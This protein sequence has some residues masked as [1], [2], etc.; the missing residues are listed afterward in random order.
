M[1][2]LVGKELIFKAL[3]KTDQRI[4]EAEAWR[5]VDLMEKNAAGLGRSSPFDTTE[6]KLEHARVLGHELA[7]DTSLLTS[8]R[9][10]DRRGTRIPLANR[11]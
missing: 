3:S 7:S 6:A 10:A 9:A 1:S 5:R 4:I 8:L 11:P 2:D